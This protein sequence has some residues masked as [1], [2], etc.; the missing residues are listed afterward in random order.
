MAQDIDTTNSFREP[1]GTQLP[2]IRL[3][4]IEAD[5]HGVLR[6]YREMHPVVTHEAGTYWVLRFSDIERVSKD[7]RLRAAETASPRKLG[8]ERGPIFEMYKYGMASANGDAHRRRRAPFSKL[9]S[10]RAISE[11]RPHI[12]RAIDDV[13]DGVYDRGEM[14]LVETLA[15]PI[16]ARVIAD[17]FGL[18]RGD[19]PDFTRDSYE[20]MQMLSFGLPPERI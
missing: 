10:A 11:M 1:A 17:L 5:P 12:R 14:E 7:E 9:F 4:E 16:P 18:P 19:I 13:I 15:S 20:I 8:L 3:R 6:K 2:V